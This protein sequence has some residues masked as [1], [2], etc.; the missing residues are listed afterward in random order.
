MKS[1]SDKLDLGSGCS[2]AT[3]EAK[4]KEALVKLENYNKL[5][6][7]TAAAM[8]EFE[9]IEKELARLSKQ[10]LLGAAMKYDNDSKEYE[11]VGGVRTSDR[12][13][14]RPQIETPATPVTVSA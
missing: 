13:R 14:S 1:V 5:K 7:Q 6:F 12:R 4:I 3:V 11:M 2:I 9:Q 8:T 10:I